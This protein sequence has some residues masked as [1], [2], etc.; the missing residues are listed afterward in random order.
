MNNS[1]VNDNSFYSTKSIN[2]KI[3]SRKCSPSNSRCDVSRNKYS[4]TKRSNSKAKN[5]FLDESHFGSHNFYQSNS[6]FK[7]TMSLIEGGEYF[8]Q[9]NTLTQ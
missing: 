3:P 5:S 7:N 8:A 9:V 1:T 4:N 2:P 6:G